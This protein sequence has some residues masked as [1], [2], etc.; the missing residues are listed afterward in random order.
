M[1]AKSIKGNGLDEVKE[2]LKDAMDGGY[3]PTLAIVF[4]SIPDEVDAV[5]KVLDERGIAVF[6]ATS[7]GEFTEQGVESESI[8]VLLLDMHPSCFKLILDDRVNGS[9]YES[10]VKVG[11]MGLEAFSNPAFLIA[12]AHIETSGEET[13]KGLV[14]QVGQDIP[15][16][17]GMSGD[18]EKYDGI[19]FTNEGTSSKGLLALVIDRDKIDVKGVAVSGWKPVGTE[20]TITKS[21]GSWIHTIDNE[22]AMEVLRRYIGE[23]LITGDTSREIAPLNSTYPIQIQN[24][25]GSPSMRPT[26]LCN[27]RDKSVM[28]GGSITEGSTF[29]FSV[30]PDFEV[31]DA[32]ME[33]ARVIKAAELPN[34]DAMIVFSCVGRLMSL[35][36]L[37]NQ[38]VV[39]L[40]NTWNVPMNGFFSL[41][42][43]G[44]VAGGKPEFHGTTCSWVALKEK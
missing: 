27:T 7:A 34:A 41:G 32:V 4:M 18:V 19:L 30:P 39:G 28:V 44:R 36:P 42:E 31:I 2:A 13:I 21:D 6:G 29:R 5:R 9:A 11:K 26:I 17:G 24:E 43:F 20:K 16:I 25:F 33:S 8:V 38:E 15:I 23:D 3:N 1:N 14:N 35:G 12:G 22:P 37:A 40:A 10:A